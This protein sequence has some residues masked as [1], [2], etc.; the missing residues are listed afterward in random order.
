MHLCTDS[1]YSLTQINNKNLSLQMF[2]HL[3]T[4]LPM[5]SFYL[6]KSYIK[7]VQWQLTAHFCSFFLG[8]LHI[9]T[10]R[11]AEIFSKMF[12][13]CSKI[14]SSHCKVKKA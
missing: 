11:C 3:L 8:I 12:Y 14:T 5:Y 4:N 6:I 1:V 13:S 2:I 7:V 10:C 9:G